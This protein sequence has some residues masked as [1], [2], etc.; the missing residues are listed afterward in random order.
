WPDVAGTNLGGTLLP[1]VLGSSQREVVHTHPLL[2]Q[3]P[4]RWGWV[5][6]G[7]MVP[8]ASCG[9]PTTVAW[10]H[11]QYGTGKCHG[12]RSKT[13]GAT[14]ERSACDHGSFDAVHDDTL[15]RPLTAECVTYL[16]GSPAGEHR[17]LH[18][19]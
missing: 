6:P 12:N 8:S 18:R 3:R 10:L 16:G 11:S 4:P 7:V 1:F 15:A 5:K 13:R 14:R 19:R 9:G 2:S 17:P